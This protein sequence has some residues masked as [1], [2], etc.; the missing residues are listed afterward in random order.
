[1]EPRHREEREEIWNQR[2]RGEMTPSHDCVY[3]RW[4]NLAF[5]SGGMAARDFVFALE[6]L[7][8]LPG[9]VA[10]WCDGVDSKAIK[11]ARSDF[12]ALFPGIERV[13]HTIA[14][15][16]VFANPEGGWRVSGKI[17]APGLP[18]VTLVDATGGS[19]QI[20]MSIIGD[21]YLATHE[22]G[23]VSYELSEQTTQSL[24]EITTQVFGA[25]EGISV[26]R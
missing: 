18:G 12:D 1:M 21:H 11:A 19:A 15:P 6:R 4:I 7:Q 24:L 9:R 20:N 3:F 17:P 16:E 13:R 2:S 26:R 8:S 23:A 10:S 22:T 25:F 14:H 5:R